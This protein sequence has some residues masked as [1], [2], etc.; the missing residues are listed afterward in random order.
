MTG[1][2]V[3][4][5]NA[6]FNSG[7]LY[8]AGAELNGGRTTNNFTNNATIV[9]SNS[10][11]FDNQALLT[12][13]GIFESGANASIH[14]PGWGGTVINTS[15][16]LVKTGTDNLTFDGGNDNGI[17]FIN[18]GGTIEA[19]NGKSV[20]FNNGNVFFN[21]GTKFT[22]TGQILV[23]NG[24]TFTGGFSASPDSNLTLTG[25]TVFANNAAFNSGTLYWAGAELNGGRT[26]NNFTNN[27]TIVLSNSNAFD[28]QALLTNNGIFE[29]GANA[30]IHDPGWGGTV[31]NTSTG[32]VKTGTDN[33]TFDGGNDN[34][35]SF[36]NNGGTIEAD[37][38]KSVIFNNGNVFF[39]DGTK[40]TGTGQILVNNGATFTGNIVNNSTLNINSNITLN[41]TNITNNNTINI[42]SDNTISINGGTNDIINNGIISKIDSNGTTDLS[43]VNL[44][45][46]VTGVIEALSGNLLLQSNFDNMGTI[47]GT[48]A[49]STSQLINDGNI[50]LYDNNG[51][52]STLTI[53]GNLIQNSDSTLEVGLSNAIAYSSLTVNGNA[54][55]GGRLKL[56]DIGGFMPTVGELFVIAASTGFETGSFLSID[57][58]SFQG[59]TFNTI[60]N[61]NNI[62][63]QVA[64]VAAVP[65]P[66]AFWLFSSA[67]VG[68]IGFNRRKSV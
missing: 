26:T 25:G 21:D 14:D 45:N 49:I 61:G 18:N 19:D 62:E 59:V 58:S 28:N 6:A 51:N 30:S 23:N 13:N 60:Y 50:K 1:G 32:L 65:V 16:G 57:T 67:L 48:A 46:N 54:T 38:G 5:N 33:L 8:W 27:A 36:I 63:L 17:S 40:F 12:N 35:I 56:D 37:N 20:I 39:N 11:A 9:L 47:E 31:I 53:N 52:P 7:T 64:S 10:N 43:G 44:T 42:A 2:T 34:G 55:W 4:A 3:F 29:S 68:F 15:T 22:G 66:A 24:A 41:G